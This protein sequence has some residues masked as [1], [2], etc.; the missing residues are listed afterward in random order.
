LIVTFIRVTASY[1]KTTETP[2]A[3]PESSFFE[4]HSKKRGTLFNGKG[5]ALII[6]KYKLIHP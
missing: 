4:V 6:E 3:I 5:I 2:A 1:I